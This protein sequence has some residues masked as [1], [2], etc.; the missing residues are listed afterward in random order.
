MPAILKNL[1]KELTVFLL[2]IIFSSLALLLSINWYNNSMIERNAAINL[3]KQVTLNYYN[4]IDRK[5]TY[6]N[7]KS[8]FTLLERSG[9]VGD[10]NRLHWASL[11]ENISDTHGIPLL[12]YTFEKQ[13]KLSTVNLQREFPGIDIYQSSMILHMQLLHE[14]DLFTVL[15]NLNESARG[16]FDVQSCAITKNTFSTAALIDSPSNL[17]FASICNLNWYTLKKKSAA[18]PERSKS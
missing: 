10:E 16:L 4:A 13:V 8:P 3:L 5:E 14:G 18:I 15:N 9:I 1:T 12:K 11:I 2:T 17:N 6:D 7:Y